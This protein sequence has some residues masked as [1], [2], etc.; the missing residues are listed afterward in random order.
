[1]SFALMDNP[2]L[3]AETQP[4]FNP[5]ALEKFFPPTTAWEEEIGGRITEFAVRGK[6]KRK[7]YEM[8]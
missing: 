6:L 8:D 4:Q 2:P 7:L 1:M 3:E 5:K